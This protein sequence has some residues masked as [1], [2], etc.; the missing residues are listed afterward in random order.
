MWEAS[1]AEGLVSRYIAEDGGDETDIPLRE[2]AAGALWQIAAAACR[3]AFPGSEIDR[4]PFFD[5]G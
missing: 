5:F 1:A 4:G 2:D 3:D